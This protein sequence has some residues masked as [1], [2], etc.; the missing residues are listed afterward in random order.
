MKKHFLFLASL[1][2]GLGQ[3][4]A[5]EVT[6]SVSDLK[7]S[8]PASNTNIET[9]YAWK[10]SP[11]HVT[12]TIEKTDGTSATLGVST[13]I[14]LNANYKVTVS[15]AGAGTL[16]SIKFT[17][18]PASQN[19]NATASTGTFASGTWTPEGATSSV[20]FTAT[21]N[22]RLTQIAVDYTP[23]S[24]YTPDVPAEATM[25]DPI[26][27]TAIDN[28][29][30]YTGS[31]PYVY[32]KANMTYYA[33]NNLGEYEEYGI[34][35]EVSTLKV[36]GGGVTEIESI[37]STNNAYINL[38][39]IP[40]ANSKAIC[41]INAETGGDWK[42]IYGCGYFDNGWKD[43]FCFF[44]TNATINLGGETGNR[45]AM[46]YGEKI[47][48]VLDA[49][50]GKMD[51]FEEDGTTLIGTITDSPKTAD[52]KTPL[53]VFAQNKDVP[54]GGKQTDCYNMLTTLYGLKLYE[55][56]VLVMDLVPAVNGEGKGGLKDKLTG[57]FYGSANSSE[58]ELSADGQAI[59]GEAG[60]PV[61]EGK[62]VKLTTNNHEYKYQN[63]EWLDCGAMAL[64][65][66]T[67][68][69]PSYKDMRNW[70]T[71][72]GHMSIF[73]GFT[74]DGTTNEINPYVGTG[75]HEPYMFQIPTIAGQDYNW[76]FIY[77][78]SAYDSWHSTEFHAYVAND[79]NLGTTETGASYNSNVIGIA[80]AFPFAGVENKPYSIDFTAK[81]NNETLVVQFGDANDG[82]EFWFKFA[83]LK[84][85]KYIYP[86]AYEPI[87]FVV[88]DDNKYT[89]LAYI[90]STGAA[91][92]NAFT[93]TYIAKASTEVD[94]KFNLYS[95]NGWAAV[96]CGR[97]GGDAGNGISLYKNG[98]ADKFGYFVGGYRN[99]NFADFP[100]FN[101]DITVEASLSGLVVN[102]GEKVNTNQTSFSSS[103]RGISMFANPEWDNPIRGRIYYM[104][105]KEDGKTVYDFQPVMRHDGV[106]G[107]Y[108]RKTAT[109]V[110]P[111]KGHYTGYGFAK[112]DDQAY[113]TY[114]NET[115]IVIVGST[116]Q[117]L[118]DVQNL[119]GATFTWTSSDETKATVAADGTVTGVAAGKVTIT[120]TTDADEGWTASY[121]LT[122]SEPNYV[123]RD[124]N[125]VGYAII[126]GGNGWGDSPLSALIDNDATTKFGTSNT[127]NA[128]AIIIASE[129]VAVQQYSFVTGADTY[130]Y[131]SR[132]PVSWKLEGSNDNETWTLIDEKVQTYQLQ[133]KSKEE[134]EF[135]VNGTET[136]KFF[137]FSATQLA[138]GFQMGE[139][140]INPQAHNYAENSELRV[141]AT[142]TAEGKVVYECDDCHALYVKPIY[143][144]EHAYA[145][146]VCTVCSAK[147]SE[148]VL[149]PTRGNDNTPYYAKFRHANAVV[150]EEYVDIEEG[151]TNADFDDSAWDELMMP[152][153]SFG[154]YHTRW[155]GEYNTFWFRRNFYVEN[156]AE[157]TK[158]TLKVT[159]DDDCTVFLN[160]KK[161]W[162]EFYWTGG[163]DDFIT[164]E[165]SS[166]DLVAGNNVL[167]MYIEQNWG[168]AYCDFG[169]FA[170]CGAT[171]EVSDAGYATFVAPC[172]VDFNGS[173]AT[174]NA[175]TCDGKYVKLAPVTTVPAGTAIIVKAEEGT[176][177][178]PKTT[179]AVLGTANELLASDGVVADGSQYILAKKNDVVGFARA[180][181]ESTIAAGKG[182]L[183]PA[184]PIKAFYPFGDDDATGL[185][186][187]SNKSNESDFIY[188]VAGQ[189]LNKMQK[190]IN[191][192]GSKKVLK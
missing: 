95:N 7:A 185:S 187:M 163:E 77:S 168:G 146:G 85:S 108:D 51:I 63:G 92:E 106:F 86:L 155:F 149:L 154:P 62:R 166:A 69:D 183:V 125:G 53:Y 12:A 71:N 171:I 135:P 173:A 2:L 55:G 88:Q 9:P 113:V 32:S 56:D 74:Y 22:F 147:A 144:T 75:G 37:K 148:V 164:V 54:G 20:T 167:A 141:E 102:G 60:I 31:E 150:D 122:V 25:G 72:D 80:E 127:E 128:W 49:V 39:Y 160:G 111:A 137:K 175:A 29:N 133:A 184:A 4:F 93:T 81:Q 121:E 45:E 1:V 48:T 36:A 98:G 67:D 90:E 109:F 177:T 17:T 124:V 162:S 191:I 68:T 57:T 23:D 47:V 50:A 3:L 151:W 179:D 58:F 115:R 73:A 130:N 153:G 19:A 181:A 100:G 156:P 129:P 145:N 89:P 34:F 136:Y 13:V 118:P 10:T 70:K 8:L 42:A 182:Y 11:Y 142:C 114:T 176:Y 178:V 192:V 30:T 112:L 105:I 189:R 97:N 120:A 99:D 76:S 103:T 139:F 38:N 116:A 78:G 158:L 40:K 152:L 132:N 131:P 126:T 21:G 165:L 107:Y 96:F 28:I 83:N 87:D 119:D 138:D 170:T 79:Y 140:W 33:L 94:I 35:S 61:Y 190:G 44:T 188:N 117:F 15:V 27:A 159:H 101:Q 26:E 14:A 180:E 104:T 64:E 66:I 174:A 157:F 5:D 143:P 16:N 110:Q 18:N 84:V 186:D 65:E 169:L 82:K 161:V 41:T 134:F 172:D 6:F 52:C 59:A 43:R 24:G 91:R 46:R 123:R